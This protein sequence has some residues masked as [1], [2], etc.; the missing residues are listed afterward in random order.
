MSSFLRDGR[1]LHARI[2]SGA[3][4]HGADKYHGSVAEEYD[5]KRE[6]SVKWQ[7][8]DVIVTS[9]LNEL[10][11]E[12]VLDVPVGT[13][14]FIPLYEELGIEHVIGLDI[15]EDMLRKAAEKNVSAKSAVYLRIGDAR[16]LGAIGEF[17]VALCCRLMRWL[18]TNETQI[19]VLSELMRVATK[20]VIF[21]ART[22]TGPL[23][24]SGDLVDAL[25][26]EK[27]WMI[28]KQEQIVE[29]FTMFMLKPVD[30]TARIDVE[31]PP[32]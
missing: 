30:Q 12:S 31:A 6:D 28:A 9:W 19:K 5:D 24:L 14:R 32:V 2:P 7:M 25:L 8:E 13:G 17:D 15:S 4:Y 21:N 3:K 26:S 1:V 11:P 27:G 18:E 22:T 20:A 16:D 10:A 23:P 29:D